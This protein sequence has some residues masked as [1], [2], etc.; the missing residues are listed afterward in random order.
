MGV[1]A[2]AEVAAPPLARIA[3]TKDSA[4]RTADSHTRRCVRVV[5]ASGD[6]NVAVPF[7]DAELCSGSSEGSAAEPPLMLPLVLPALSSPKAVAA[8]LAGPIERLLLARRLGLAE[9]VIR[10][11]R[12]DRQ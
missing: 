11:A 9:A 6:S 10:A 12:R 5:V 4:V 7:E 3:G 1:T 2:G 8:N